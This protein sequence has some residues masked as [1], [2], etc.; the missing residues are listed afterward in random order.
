M[1]DETLRERLG[2]A[3]GLDEV[4]EIPENG[5]LAIPP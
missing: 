1:L 3:S 2:E 4:K 5:Y